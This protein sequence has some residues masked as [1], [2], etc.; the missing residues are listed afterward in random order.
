MVSPYFHGCVR[1]TLS[2]CRY[3]KSAALIA[4]CCA[5]G[6]LQKVLGSMSANRGSMAWGFEP[7]N[8]WTV[9]SHTSHCPVRLISQV[10]FTA[11]KSLSALILSS[12]SSHAAYGGPSRWRQDPRANIIQSWPFVDRVSG[13]II[14]TFDKSTWLPLARFKHWLRFPAIVAMKSF[15]IMTA[16]RQGRVRTVAPSPEKGIADVWSKWWRHLAHWRWWIIADIYKVFEID[17]TSYSNTTMS[18]SL[19]PYTSQAQ[20]NEHTLQEKIN[21]I[22]L[23]L[24]LRQRWLLIS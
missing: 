14:T 20:N 2:I 22:I 7:L 18:T 23:G 15:L 4:I 3:S 21:G 10:N 5:A 24:Q 6:Q 8:L 12:V 19:D 17:F 11:Q 9:A 1:L 13:S 16:H